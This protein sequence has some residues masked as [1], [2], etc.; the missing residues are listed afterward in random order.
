[1]FYHHINPTA[2]LDIEFIPLPG[3]VLAYYHWCSSR[4]QMSIVFMKVSDTGTV[5]CVDKVLSGSLDR[6][7]DAD[8]D[9]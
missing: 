9:W 4:I 8:S 2:F 1:M 6:L 7:Y 3:Q 5:I